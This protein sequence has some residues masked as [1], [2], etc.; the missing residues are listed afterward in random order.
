M[1]FYLQTDSQTERTN[2]TL[3]QYLQMYCNHLQTNWVDLLPMVSFAYNN[4]ILA[5][6]AQSLF[7]LNYGYYPQQGIS[8][9]AADQSPAAREYLKKLA[10]VQEKAA[11]LLKNA[12]E[13]Q[14]VQY[15]RKRQKAPAFE[16]GELT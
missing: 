2:Q 14:A 10:G 5:S 16:K 1:A 12:Q 7:F 11:G 13:A 6:T 4:G 9:D 8:P 15:N 3:E